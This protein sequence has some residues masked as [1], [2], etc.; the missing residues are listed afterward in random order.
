[1]VP[2]NL[3]GI[4]TDT[5]SVYDEI[6]NKF[7]KMTTLVY[8]TDDFEGG[9][10]NFFTDAFVPTCTIKPRRGRVLLFDIDRFHEASPVISGVKRWIGVELVGFRSI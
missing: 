1:M 5:G 3:F 10:T 9:T 2:G 8:L 6:E 7:S 4:H